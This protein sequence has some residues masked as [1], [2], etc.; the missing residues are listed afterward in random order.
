MYPISVCVWVWLRK[1]DAHTLWRRF[2]LKKGKIFFY[3]KSFSFLCVFFYFVEKKE[4][5]L[6]FFSSSSYQRLFFLLAKSMRARERV[7]EREREQ[8]FAG[9]WRNWKKKKICES[10]KS[11]NLAVKKILL[12]YIY[13]LPCHISHSLNVCSSS[14]N[15]YLMKNATEKSFRFIAIS[16]RFY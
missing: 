7:S 14:N 5:K 1:L 15:H 10:E 9:C 12:F 4:R 8:K 16:T 11:S 13:N 6:L 3:S 2:F